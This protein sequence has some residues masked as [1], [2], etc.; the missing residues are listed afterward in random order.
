MR[1]GR[2]FTGLDWTSDPNQAQR[3]PDEVQ[4]MRACVRHGLKNVELVVRVP[5]FLND[6]CTVRLC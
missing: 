1:T 2:Y 4:A 5:G 3:Y 6:L